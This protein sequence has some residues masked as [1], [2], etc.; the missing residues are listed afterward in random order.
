MIFHS[1][2]SGITTYGI[3]KKRSDVMLATGQAPTSLLK[4]VLSSWKGRMETER[5]V[6]NRDADTADLRKGNTG[7]AVTCTWSL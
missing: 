7:A 5:C 2:I 1:T 3:G 4:T 6:Q